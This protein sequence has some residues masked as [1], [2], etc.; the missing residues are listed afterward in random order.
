VRIAPWPALFVFLALLSAG[1]CASR[2]RG[3]IPTSAPAPPP[4]TTPGPAIKPAPPSPA[5]PLR[6]IEEGNASWY[7]VPYHGRKAANGEVYDMYKLTA[8]HR[9]LPFDT[10]VRVTNL[11]NGRRTQV[12]IT[13]RGP[14]VEGRIIDLSLAAARDIDMVAMGVAR[15]RLELVSGPAPMEGAFTVQVGAFLQQDNAVKLRQRLERRYQPV[16][17]HEYDSPKGMFYRVRVGRVA[18][19]AA[20][21]KLAG[22][23]QTQENLTTFVVR[24]D[25][26]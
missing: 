21:D 12:R 19:E 26:K 25:E 5:G 22:K 8:A 2:H 17:V 11:S 9:T 3:G 16:F 7:G 13:D 4:G 14:F 15:V 24:L 6:A 20:A 10:V 1:G 23:L 18:N